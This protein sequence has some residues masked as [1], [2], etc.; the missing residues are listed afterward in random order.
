MAT[1]E[2]DHDRVA[3]VTLVECRIASD[4]AQRV[5]VEPTHDEPIWPPRRQGV[6][7]RGWHD[8]GWTG[9][10][11][12]D[13]HRALGYATPVEPDGQPARIA[14]T[15]RPAADESLTARDVVRSL[16]DP[17]PTRDAVPPDESD[18]SSTVA[19]GSPE[20]ESI[21]AANTSTTAGDRGPPTDDGRTAPEGRETGGRS[22]DLNA[23]ETRLWTARDLAA[24]TTVEEARAAV[25]RAGGLAAVRDLVARLDADRERLETLRERTARLDAEAEAVEVPLDSLERL[26]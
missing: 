5:T 20:V 9:V 7:A 2:C 16:G 22:P 10:V 23:I 8:D 24:V 19:T 15:D 18:G 1:I 14:A 12:A 3:G 4:V 26:V 13:G 11:P 25:Q 6:P 17:T 21:E